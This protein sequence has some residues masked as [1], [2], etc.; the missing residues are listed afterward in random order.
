MYAAVLI[1]IPFYSGTSELCIYIY[2]FNK[3]KFPLI[4]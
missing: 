4:K 1:F 3:N 2:K